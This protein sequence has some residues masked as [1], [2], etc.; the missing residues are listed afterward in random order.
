MGRYRKLALKYHPD[1]NT[2]DE[3]AATKFAEVSEAFEVL[4]DKEKRQIYDQ[5]GH[6]GMDAQAN[7]GQGANGFSAASGSSAHVPLIHDFEAHMAGL[8][9]FQPGADS[10]GSGSGDDFAVFC[11]DVLCECVAGE[12]V[13]MILTHVAIHQMLSN[14]HVTA[15]SA[16]LKNMKMVVAYYSGAW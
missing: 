2:D 1:K 8:Q 15:N 6:A 5:Y 7:G 4:T 16:A 9:Q 11:N 3:D 12:K 13:E 14:L 10:S